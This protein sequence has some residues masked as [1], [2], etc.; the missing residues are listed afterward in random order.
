MPPI[1]KPISPSVADL[2][3]LSRVLF[4]PVHFPS[5]Q[6]GNAASSP[7]ASVL[8]H[9]CVFKN[10]LSRG[11]WVAQPVERLTSAQVTISPLVRLSPTLGCSLLSL[12]SPLRILCPPPLSLPFPHLRPLSLKNKR[13]LRN[14]SLPSCIGFQEGAN[15]NA[16]PTSVQSH[17]CHGGPPPAL[18]GN[19]EVKGEGRSQD[20]FRGHLSSRC[21][22][23]LLERPVL[24]AGKPGQAGV[25]GSIPRIPGS[26]RLGAGPGTGQTDQR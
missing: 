15:I 1:P 14:L 24:P 25:T 7:I 20:S 6:N 12:W 2:E 9:S 18:G 8:I 23:W 10:S 19:T 3:L 11:A 17:R 13:H 4:S 16:S 5:F 22:S 26:G 21:N